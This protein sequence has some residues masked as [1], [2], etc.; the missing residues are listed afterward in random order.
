VDGSA[1]AQNLKAHPHA[2]NF[3]VYLLTV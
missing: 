2:K 3:R 1:T